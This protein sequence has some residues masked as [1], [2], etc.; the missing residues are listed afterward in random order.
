MAS[1]VRWGLSDCT[2]RSETKG[3]SLEEIHD[4]SGAHSSRVN[5]TSEMVHNDE[6]TNRT[7]T[8][9]NSTQ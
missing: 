4:A 8:T 1:L 9:Y 7:R 6:Q 5:G 3:K 2:L